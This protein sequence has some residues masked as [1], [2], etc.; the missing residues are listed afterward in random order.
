[1]KVPSCVG[2]VAT[3]IDS[4]IALG[5][6]ASDSNAITRLSLD[7]VKDGSRHC[8]EM[9]CVLRHFIRPSGWDAKPG[10]ATRDSMVKYFKKIHPS[11]LRR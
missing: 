7:S 6:S 1:M 2:T 10:K 4:L 3:W 5:E 11:L 8:S 9:L